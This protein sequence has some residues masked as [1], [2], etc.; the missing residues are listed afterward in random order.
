MHRVVTEAL[1][2]DLPAEALENYLYNN[3]NDFFFGPREEQ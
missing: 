1:A 3:A 2:L